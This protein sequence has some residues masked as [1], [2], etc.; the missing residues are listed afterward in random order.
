MV[1]DKAHITRN[2]DEPTEIFTCGIG[3]S[4]FGPSINRELN[5][6]YVFMKVDS[7][8]YTILFGKIRNAMLS[9]IEHIVLFSLSSPQDIFKPCG[10]LVVYK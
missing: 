5:V 7:K 10:L 4:Q 3:C 9:N 2:G 1:K 8:Y 6:K